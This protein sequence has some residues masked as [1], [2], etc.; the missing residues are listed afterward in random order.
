[1]CGK[2]IYEVISMNYEARAVYPNSTERIASSGPEIKIFYL[3]RFLVVTTVIPGN[4]SNSS[5]I[6]IRSTTTHCYKYPH[7]AEYL[8]QKHVI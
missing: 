7:R 8:N 6:V 4:S 5:F 1:M 2:I 3:N